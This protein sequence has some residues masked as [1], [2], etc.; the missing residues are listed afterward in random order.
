[1][2]C[3]CQLVTCLCSPCFSMYEAL[4]IWGQILVIL[5]ILA[6]LVVLTGFAAQ[7]LDDLYYG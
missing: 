5:A 7:A 2:C 6:P 1:M 3:L 4:P